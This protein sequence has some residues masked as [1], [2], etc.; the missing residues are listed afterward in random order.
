[1]KM[2]LKVIITKINTW[3][4]S[5]PNPNPLT[6]AVLCEALAYFRYQSHW[7]KFADD[8]YERNLASQCLRLMGE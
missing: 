1:M 6:L 8:P 7:A 5:N 4:D 3:L 2:K